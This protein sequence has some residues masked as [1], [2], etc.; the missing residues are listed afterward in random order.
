MR[1]RINIV[2]GGFKPDGVRSDKSIEQLEESFKEFDLF[3]RIECPVCHSR[4]LVVLDISCPN[5]GT[6]VAKNRQ[7]LDKDGAEKLAGGLTAGELMKRAEKWWNKTGRKY[8]KHMRERPG[9]SI[10]QTP[11]LS[12]GSNILMGR[13]FSELSRGEKFS[14]CSK[15]HQAW[16]Q[17]EHAEPDIP[18]LVI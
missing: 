17:E 6:V 16:Y 10:A 14:V 1:K 13:P 18:T 5:C 3:G 4:Q 8:F 2:P 9:D 7:P 11:Q 12:G 15:Y